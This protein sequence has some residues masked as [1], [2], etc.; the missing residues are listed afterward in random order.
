MRCSDT[1]Q[2]CNF[3]I[4]ELLYATVLTWNRLNCFI[5][6]C[7]GHTQLLHKDLME[8]QAPKNTRG[9]VSTK[10]VSGDV[11]LLQGT[12]T[13]A[14]QLRSSGS[15][16]RWITS[17]RMKPHTENYGWSKRDGW[18]VRARV[19]NGRRSRKAAV[20]C[21]GKAVKGNWDGLTPLPGSSQHQFNARTLNLPTSHVHLLDLINGQ[22]HF[23]PLIEKAW[24]M[25]V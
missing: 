20:G 21:L 1:C 4:S 8:T 14:S 17:G 11:C 2:S 13:L 5:T 23:S 16:S 9:R 22:T 6:T 15:W 25:H 18:P 7:Q 10:G 3:A 12:G 19:A 24:P